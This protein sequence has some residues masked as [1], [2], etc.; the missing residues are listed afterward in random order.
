MTIALAVLALASCKN[1]YKEKKILPGDSITVNFRAGSASSKTAFGEASA[2][3]Y[4]PVR[5]TDTDN[6]AVS[7]NADGWQS[8]AAVPSD[9]K[10]TASFSGDFSAAECY[11]FYAVSPAASVKDMNVS[12]GAW[13]LNIPWLQTPGT[14]TPDPKAIILGASTGETPDLPN[15][16]NFI[17]SHLTAYLRLTLENVPS[18][19]G[20]V[21]S[22]DVSSDKAFAGDWYFSLADGSFDGREASHSVRLVTYSVSDQWIACAPVDMSGAKI[23]VTVNGSAGSV[24]RTV[25]LPMERPYASGMVS[26][27]SVDM[28]SATAVNVSAADASFVANTVPGFYP[29]SGTSFAYS[30]ASM[31]L[32]REYEGGEVAFS[33]IASDGASAAFFSGIPEAAAVGDNFSLYYTA[34]S[35]LGSNSAEYSVAVVAEDGAL[36]WLQTSAG[37]RFIVK[38]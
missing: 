32:S 27:L 37:D 21:A 35:T 3:G 30:P 24:R 7:L 14:S 6:V 8:L 22:I 29:K 33:I 10:A 11:R 12:K 5:W 18:S 1:D 17:F 20:T 26:K 23:S 15:P 19:V 34:F 28:A 36:L 9:S 2:L 31:Q 38:K 13:L 16:V 4:Y 25:T